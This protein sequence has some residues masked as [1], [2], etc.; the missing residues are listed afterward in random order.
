MGTYEDVFRAAT[1]DPEIF[2]LRRRRP[3]TGR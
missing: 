1:E 2:W 3:S